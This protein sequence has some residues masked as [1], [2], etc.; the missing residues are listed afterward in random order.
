VTA[1][2]TQEDQGLI[3]QLVAKIGLMVS[4]GEQTR[5]QTARMSKKLD[6]FRA[7]QPVDFRAIGSATADAGGV[8]V[9]QFSP[10]G[11]DQGHKW[12]IQNVVLGGDTFA[13]AA[14]SSAVEYYASAMD[15]RTLLDTSPPLTD[16]VDGTTTA[17]PF[18]AFYSRGQYTL[19]PGEKLYVRI[20][21]GTEGQQYVG[22]A[23]GLDIQEAANAQVTGI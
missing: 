20:T 21:G 11:P 15:F 16:L 9:I 8:A 1:T 10:G 18:P 19:R 13:T 23:R 17:L 4:V 5:D 6:A 22:V 3:A 2:E 12:E 14:A 7:Q